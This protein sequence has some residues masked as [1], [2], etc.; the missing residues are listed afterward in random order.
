M[1]SRI[2]LFAL[3]LFICLTSCSSDDECTAENWI[4]TYILDPGSEDCSSE[5]VSLNEQIVITAGSDNNTVVFEGISADANTCNI[6]ATDP[7][8][9]LTITAELDGDQITVSGFGC[10]GT[11]T[12]Q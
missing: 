7:F 12:R 2:I 11:Y 3:G 10:T 1:K 5:S 6:E 9:G 4:G 8:F